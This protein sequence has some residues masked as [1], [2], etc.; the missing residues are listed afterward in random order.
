MIGFIVD[1]HFPMLMI[2]E[3]FEFFIYRSVGS[4]KLLSFGISGNGTAGNTGR[5]P[6]RTKFVMNDAAR[7]ELVS[8]NPPATT[9]S[10]RS[11]RCGCGGS[12]RRVCCGGRVYGGGG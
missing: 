12:I 3:S 9:S 11:I 2:R 6:R 7:F 10:S 5:A 4:L 8:N 1:L